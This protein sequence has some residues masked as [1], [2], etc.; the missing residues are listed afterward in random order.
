M[1]LEV[2]MPDTEEPTIPLH[3]DDTLPPWGDLDTGGKST[4]ASTALP[5]H[6]SF[7]LDDAGRERQFVRWWFHTL[8]LINRYLWPRYD[9]RRKVWA[10]E[11]VRFMTELTQADLHLLLRIQHPRRGGRQFEKAL[12]SALRPPGRVTH[13]DL[14]TL[15][16][17]NDGA[18][19]R[20][21]ERR[22]GKE[23]RSRW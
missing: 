7:E 5:S 8:S 21:E 11:S 16:D 13:H 14:F 18:N 10:G 4:L 1:I 15:E 19:M 6:W 12:T 23:G 9:R 17:Q 3:A 20:S 2:D 22:V